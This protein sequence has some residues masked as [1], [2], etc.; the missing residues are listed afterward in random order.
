MKNYELLSFATPAALA[1]A[2]AEAW[3]SK[4]ES[5][6]YESKPLH[7]ALSGGRIARQLFSA[8]AEQAVKRNVSFARVHFFWADERCVPP[9]DPESNF[10]V[11]QKSLFE[12]LR[13]GS[14]Q[15]HRIRGELPPEEAARQAA[16]E[17]RGV[18]PANPAGEPLLDIIFLG[19]GEDGHVASLFPEPVERVDSGAVYLAVTAS[20]PPPQRIT[21]TYAVLG[22]AREVWVLASGPGKTEALRDS[23]R[24]GSQRPLGRVL[25]MRRETRI[26][27]DVPL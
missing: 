9:Q 21:L 1:E 6:N 3:I 12:L 23:L 25:A 8:A 19:M 15:I 24:P 17:L 14:S 16:G 2:A 7:V 4:V 22:A 10:G 5:A 27:S 18:A 13:I 26:Y 20:K 11:A